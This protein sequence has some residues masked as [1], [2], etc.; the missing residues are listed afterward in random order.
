MEK[1]R[2]RTRER[3][4]GLLKRHALSGEPYT[5]NLN[6]AGSI[7]QARQALKQVRSASEEKEI[8]SVCERLERDLAE[9]E[10]KQRECDLQLDALREDLK[11]KE[12]DLPQSELLKVILSERYPLEPLHFANAM[13]GLPFI[14]W[15]QSHKRC[16]KHDPQSSHG[17]CYRRFVIVAKIITQPASSA[18]EMVENMR[19]HLLDKATR[20]DCAYDELRAFWYHLKCSIEAV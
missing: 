12:A 16:S 8:R 13:A 19:A 6:L 14:G 9:V 20:E 1:Q 11:Q 5:K 7:E 10:A 15:R 3:F 18:G 2:Q 4:A 17:L